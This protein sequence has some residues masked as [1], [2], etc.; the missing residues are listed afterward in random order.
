MQYEINITTEQLYDGIIELYDS[1]FYNKINDFIINI[2]IL[3]NVNILHLK[4]FL[5][6]SEALIKEF[7]I[8]IDFN[9][10]GKIDIF[11]D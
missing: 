9:F 10:T 3:E 5:E 2:N 6:L 7:N 4:D 1:C 11:N 8:N